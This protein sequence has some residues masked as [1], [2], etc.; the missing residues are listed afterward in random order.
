MFQAAGLRQPIKANL[1]CNCIANGMDASGRLQ[2]SITK[3]HLDALE[4][5]IHSKVWTR[6]EAACR[7]G[8][9]RP[10]SRAGPSVSQWTCEV[11]LSKLMT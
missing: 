3:V 7:G 8:C 6:C 10:Q 2:A 9:W 1:T 11:L 5:V 4:S